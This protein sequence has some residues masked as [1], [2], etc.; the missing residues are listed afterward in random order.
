MVVQ[1]PDGGSFEY[2]EIAVEPRHLEEWN[3]AL[4]LIIRLGQEHY[5][6]HQAAEVSVLMPSIV[7]KCAFEMEELDEEEFEAGVAV[8]IATRS[9]LRRD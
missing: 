3:A 2:H 8:S 5:E 4:D 1:L 9:R 6:T 7:S